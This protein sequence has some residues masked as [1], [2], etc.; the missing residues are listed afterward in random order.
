MCQNSTLYH[1][2]TY[3]YYLPLRIEIKIKVI[4]SKKLRIQDNLMI[5]FTE[6]FALE[7]PRRGLLPVS[8]KTS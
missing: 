1:T 3:N 7:K 8:V 6:I 4:V 5:T 2:N